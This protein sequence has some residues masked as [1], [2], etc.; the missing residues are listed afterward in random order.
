MPLAQ[1]DEWIERILRITRTG[2][3]LWGRINGLLV[4][5]LASISHPIGNLS[6][7]K[8]NVYRCKQNS[9]SI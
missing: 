1:K 8:D 5:A 2:K 4:P 6:E 3:C 7:A 9:P